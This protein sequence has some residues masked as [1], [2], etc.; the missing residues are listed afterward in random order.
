MRRISGR[1]E[2]SIS[3]KIF[4]KNKIEKYFALKAGDINRD[5]IFKK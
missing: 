3:P 5:N 2:F 4:S 1:L